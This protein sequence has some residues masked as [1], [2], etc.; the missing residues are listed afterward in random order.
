MAITQL[1]TVE[2]VLSLKKRDSVAPSNAHNDVAENPS[3]ARKHVQAMVLSVEP[4][5]S[6]ENEAKVVMAKRIA[7]GLRSTSRRAAD[8]TKSVIWFYTN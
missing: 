5:R 1:K 2:K 6:A 3:N 7:L 8:L 4:V